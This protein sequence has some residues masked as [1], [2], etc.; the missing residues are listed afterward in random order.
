MRPGLL[1][2]GTQGEIDLSR[3]ESYLTDLWRR[4]REDRAEGVALDRV[5]VLNLIVYGEDPSVVDR[6]E[7]LAGVLPARH[8]GR[9]V[10][11]HLDPRRP[12]Q[13]IEAGVAA[14]CVR[15][16]IA[17]REVCGELITLDAP[18]ETRRYVAN[19]VAGLLVSDLP[20][21]LWWTGRPAPEDDLFREMTRE[22]SDVVIVDSSAGGAAG[23]TIRGLAD[24]LSGEHRHALLGDLAWARLLP[25][26]QVVAEFFDQQHTRA[27]V[28]D[29]RDVRI[30]V[31]EEAPPAEALLLTGWLASR[32]RWWLHGVTRSDVGLQL[33]YRS[34][35]GEHK[36]A[37][38]IGDG[39]AP[40]GLVAVELTAGSSATPYRFE[41]HRG[42]DI[43]VIHGH[44]TAPDGVRTPRT[45][46]LA[47]PEDETLVAD[48]LDQRMTDHV[49]EAALSAAAE[50]ARALEP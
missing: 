31:S 34:Q 23:A 1:R 21:A 45:A 11:I 6:A 33:T 15:E 13:R 4:M 35:A 17:R 39:S 43:T 25:W 22:L 40:A 24:W 49:Y 46:G 37:L 18:A 42:H 47:E 36:V 20:V 9:I 44:V 50:V 38:A 8:P 16:V 5:R 12:G 14:H 28:S 32:L 19:A 41:V 3:V 27:L 26:R 30:T 7:R 29:I 10:A 2:S 48:L